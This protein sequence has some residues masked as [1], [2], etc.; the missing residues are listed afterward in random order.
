MNSEAGTQP[1]DIVQSIV[2]TRQI[3]NMMDILILYATY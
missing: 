1:I 3:N 2:D